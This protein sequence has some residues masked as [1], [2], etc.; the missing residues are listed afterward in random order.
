[1]IARAQRTMSV[2]AYMIERTAIVRISPLIGVVSYFVEKGTPQ[3]D[4]RK[5]ITGAL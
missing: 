4:L 2:H 3:G 5:A 1:M